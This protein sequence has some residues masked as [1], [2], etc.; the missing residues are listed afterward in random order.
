MITR[1]KFIT[2]LTSSLLAFTA[3]N[4]LSSVN[5]YRYYLDN[6]VP[7]DISDFIKS[8]TPP[9]QPEA[10]AITEDGYSKIQIPYYN[11]GRLNLHNNN[12]EKY[13]FEFRDRYGNYNQEIMN[14]MDWFFRCNHDQSYITM[15][16]GV[17]EYL[18]YISKLLNDPVI[19]IHSAYRTPKFNA[20]LRKKNEN[21]AKNSLHMYG[22]AIDF[23]IPG[24][25]LKK[26]CQTAQI[27]RNT[28]GFGGIGYYQR[29]GFIHIDSGNVKTWSK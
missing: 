23:S 19:K 28:L 13:H 6:E 22:C 4:C 18:N 2:G 1:R 24:I 26:V 16:K 8:E 21:V 12:K 5:R 14:Y 29:N 17:V 7:S 25:S 3:T 10:F 9:P 20:L 27:A 15:N 11:D